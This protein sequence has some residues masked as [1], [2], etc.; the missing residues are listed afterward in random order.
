MHS[1]IRTCTASAAL[2]VIACSVN[3]GTSTARAEAMNHGDTAADSAAPPSVGQ[4]LFDKLTGLMGTWDAQT[5]TGVLTDVFKPFALGTAILGEEWINGKQITSTIFYVVD[6]ELRADHYCDFKN[7]PRYTAVPAIDPEV[8]DFE[9]RDATNLDTHPMHFHNT[10]WR[11]VDATH[12]IQDWFILGG[13]KP[14]SLAHLE[15]TKR[16]DGAPVPQ[17]TS[18]PPKAA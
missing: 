6:G 1:F 18:V 8:L 9:F 12:L 16:A 7:Q 14:V 15:F 5:K 4:T 11:I 10:K 17:S 2:L 13:S 3:I